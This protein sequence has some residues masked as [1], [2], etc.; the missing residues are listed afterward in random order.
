VSR[1]YLAL[2]TSGPQSSLC[3]A[4][5]TGGFFEKQIE[6]T[7]SH[8]ESLAIG[9][10]DLLV[11]AKISAPDLSIIL[12]AAGPGSFTGLRIGFSFAKG[13]ALAIQCPVQAVSS[14][15]AQAYEFSSQFEVLVSMRDAR[16]DEVF[17]EIFRRG[18]AGNIEIID[19]PRIE[20]ASKIPEL[21]RAFAE[22]LTLAESQI[23]LISSDDLAIYGLQCHKPRQSARHMLALWKAQVGDAIPAFSLSD[24]IALQPTYMRAV[25]A[26]TIAERAHLA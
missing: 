23:G 4:S 18:I 5:S 1:W 10:R 20:A 12:V 8:S 7:D 9:V 26:R 25:A 3:L 24:L 15:R 21:T 16:R 11:E 17:L 13:L 14:L 22:K 2:E 6:Q 19:G